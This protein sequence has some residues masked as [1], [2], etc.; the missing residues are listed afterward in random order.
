M[1][2]VCEECSTEFQGHD[3]RRFCS[4]KCANRHRVKRPLPI[5]VHVKTPLARVMELVESGLSV[6]RACEKLGIEHTYIY[7]RLHRAGYDFKA[8]AWSQTVTVPEDHGSLGYMAGIFD[9]EGSLVHTRSGHWHLCVA[10]THKETV[11]WLGQFGG[12]VHFS[13]R[14]HMPNHKNIWRWSVARRKDIELLLLAMLPYLHVKRDRAK[15][16]LADLGVVVPA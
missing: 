2:M 11:D 3:K 5:E 6:R 14:S 1:T 10:M 8:A 12:N 13:D 7:R 9:G 16:C 15:E 4:H